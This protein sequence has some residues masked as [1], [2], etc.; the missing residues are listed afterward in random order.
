MKKASGKSNI[1]ILRDYVD[2]VR[3]FTQVGFVGNKNKYRKDGEKWK[4]SNGVEW[5][6]RD[7][8]N[9]R[10]TKTQ[11]D[12]IRELI[13]KDRRCKCGQDVRWGSKL[14]N[15]FF[16]RTG[17]CETCLITYETN[18]RILGVYDVYE[19]YKLISYEMGRLKEAQEKIKDV[20]KFFEESGGD[21]E[22]ICNSEG[23]VERWKNTNSDM[24]KEDATKDLKF[25][26]EKIDK[27]SEILEEAKQLYIDSAKKYNI[28]IYV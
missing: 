22:M 6:R 4:D 25:V 3:P 10:L 14:D 9:V 12:L 28:E 17:L 2:G 26:E 15:Y 23:F 19:K 11:S 16:N 18:L 8:Q 1:Q 7:G 27:L 24:I 21:V 13:S 20:I 5:E